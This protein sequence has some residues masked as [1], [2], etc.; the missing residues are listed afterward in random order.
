MKRQVKTT[1]DGSSTIYVPELDEHYH[2]TFGAIQESM[3]VFIESGLRQ[4]TKS[5]LS[6]FEMGFGTGL[7]CLLTYLNAGSNSIHYSSI[8]K[9]PVEKDM[10]VELNFS[11]ILNLTQSQL[12]IFDNLHSCPWN[13]STAID[14]NFVLHKI[15]GDI[16]G[17]VHTTKYDLVYFDAFAPEVQPNLWTP[18]IFKYIY[19]SL[20]EGGVLT[21]YCAKGV[22]RRTLQVSGFKV[23]RLPGPPGKREMLRATKI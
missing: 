7:N 16:K 10:A 11:H 2:S 8:E 18:D 12:D 17:F 23:E 20:N 1:G 5:D 14:K 21:T 6:I 22:I 3:H 9:Y 13:T 19:E 15:K 4:M